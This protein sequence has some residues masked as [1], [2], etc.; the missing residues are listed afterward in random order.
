MRTSSAVGQ[1]TTA[2]TAAVPDPPIASSDSPAAPSDR[3]TTASP[4]PQ[5]IRLSETLGKYRR[6]SRTAFGL[7]VGSAPVDIG[8]GKRVIAWERRAE[9]PLAGMAAAFLAAY[10]LQV[11]VLHP[12]AWQRSTFSAVVWI[13]WL[14]F[15]ADYVVRVSIAKRPAVYAS[16]HWVDLLIIA[17]PVLRPLRVLRVIMLVRAL[18]RKAA[19]ALRGRVVVYGA[20]TASILIYCAS[21]TV[22][23]AERAHGNIKSFG[24]ALWWSVVT[25]TTVGYGDKFP[26]S[27]QGRLVGVGLMVTGV[28]LFGA[29][30]ASFA[31]L[32]AD[33]LRDEDAEEQATTKREL[34]AVRAQLTRVERQLTTLQRTLTARDRAPK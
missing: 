5:R 11:L 25:M 16:R 30:T 32:L 2:G 28:G 17:L 19:G 9:W 22:L 23:E 6:K 15:A 10:S 4:A 20:I 8:Q 18:N 24:D 3:A 27:T 14:A 12:V 13:T 33:Q 29:V 7:I 21:L 1:Q 26:I 31:T 34:E